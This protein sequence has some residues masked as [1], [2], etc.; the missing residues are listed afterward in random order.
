METHSS[1]TDIE[2]TVT[3][4]RQ[5]AV[6]AMGKRYCRFLARYASYMLGC[7]AT[8]VRISKNVNR[9]ASVIGMDAHIVTLPHN[10]I[11]HLV[12]NGGK[13]TYYFS[14][15]IARVPAS[16]YINTRLSRLSWEMADRTVDLATAEKRMESVVH[17][18]NMSPWAV[19]VLVAVANASFCRLF[20]GDS[21]AMLIVA[22][23]TAAGYAVKNILVSHHWDMKTVWLLSATTAS[24]TAAFLSFKG[25]LTHTPDV[26][27][28]TSVLYLIP[29]IPYID[30]VSD[31]LDGHYL[32]GISRFIFAT[33]LTGCIAIGLTLGF[34]TLNLDI[35]K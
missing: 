11:V 13:D 32:C 14:C 3:P 22:V 19:L 35:L 24:L 28:A 6:E 23:A 20:G 31:I 5:N 16:F 30:S 10:I 29:G 27:L 34:I 9:I 4:A 25:T 7:G 15:P 8:C 26:A 12:G 17:H 33:V 2:S 1:H 18:K 21:I